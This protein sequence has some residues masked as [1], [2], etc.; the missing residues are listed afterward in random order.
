MGKETE[1]DQTSDKNKKTALDYERY[2]RMGGGKTGGFN[3]KNENFNRNLELA[4]E[5]EE[6]ARSYD[7]FGAKSDDPIKST[8]GSF[9]VAQGLTA[10]GKFSLNNQAKA[11]KAGGMPV[12]DKKGKMQGVVSENFFG[13]LVYSGNSAYSPIG[14]KDSGF[15]NASGSYTTDAKMQQDD[16]GPSVSNVSSAPKQEKAAGSIASATSGTQLAQKN[17]ALEA[18]VGGVDRRNFLSRGRGTGLGG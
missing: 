10:V 18:T 5:L 1:A 2:N 15:N 8:L 3:S 12:F 6:K 7:P 4:R 9:P 13:A 16:D 14:R 11:L 17:T